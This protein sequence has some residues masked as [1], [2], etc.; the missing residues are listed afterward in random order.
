MVRCLYQRA[1]AVTNM[2]KTEV[3]TG[4]STDTEQ[5]KGIILTITY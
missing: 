1:R 5:K 4:D 2:S 3:P